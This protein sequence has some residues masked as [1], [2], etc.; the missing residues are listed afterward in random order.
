MRQA[1]RHGASGR[2][3]CHDCYTIAGTSS[4]QPLPKNVEELT[5]GSMVQSEHT[6]AVNV[7]IQHDLTTDLADTEIA[8]P[9]TAVDLAGGGNGPVV[10]AHDGLDL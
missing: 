6:R 8:E 9:S 10:G 7:R 3:V 5:G 4:P 1:H 2:N